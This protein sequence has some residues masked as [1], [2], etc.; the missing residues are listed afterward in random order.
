MNPQE[1]MHMRAGIAHAYRE[2]VIDILGFKIPGA[3]N[4]AELIAL[5]KR[6]DARELEA[7][8]GWRTEPPFPGA[9]EP[10]EQTPAGWRMMC[11]SHVFVD[12]NVAGIIFLTLFSNKPVAVFVN[13]PDYQIPATFTALR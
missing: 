12:G 10:P 3:R 1:L 11:A 4:A 9:G 13:Q 5:A 6:L 2:R 8:R 7:E